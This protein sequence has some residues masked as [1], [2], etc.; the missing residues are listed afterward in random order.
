MNVVLCNFDLYFQDQTSQVA[1]LTSKGWKMQTLI[2]P[3]DKK[4]GIYHRMAPLR[5]LYIIT[6][7]YIFKVTN[8]EM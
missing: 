7:T 2:L 5:M 8:S 4:S 1:I 3:K 6:L